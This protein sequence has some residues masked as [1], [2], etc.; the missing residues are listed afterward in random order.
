MKG[1]LF[2]TCIVDDLLDS[3]SERHDAAVQRFSGLSEE[4]L[5]LVSVITLGEIEYGIRVAP[6]ERAEALAGFRR[7]VADKFPYVLPI[8][9]ATS[10]PYGELRGRLFQQ[11]SP[12]EARGRKRR[13]EQIQDPESGLAMG[14]QEND[15]WLVAQAYEHN[16]ILVTR[17]KMRSL[18]AIASPDVQFEFW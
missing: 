7:L 2:D 15:L 4:D 1:R 10:E 18:A 8:Q 13:V 16:L 5:A 9:E 14:I 17:D 3:T 11:Y 12:R 6:V